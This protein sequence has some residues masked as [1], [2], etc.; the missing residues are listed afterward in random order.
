MNESKSPRRSRLSGRFSP[1]NLLVEPPMGFSIT[2]RKVEN[3]LHSSFRAFFGGRKP[4][5]ERRLGWRC[6]NGHR[7]SWKSQLKLAVKQQEEAN[8]NNNKNKKKQY[9]RQYNL[10]WSSELL[11][12]SV[13]FVLFSFEFGF[14]SILALDYLALFLLT[15]S[16]ILES[17]PLECKFSF[18]SSTV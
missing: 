14:V 1:V 8:G 16:S 17:A 5:C 7:E 18:P 12:D 11:L 2:L 9:R 13:L 10:H 6:C 3:W 4:R 15:Q